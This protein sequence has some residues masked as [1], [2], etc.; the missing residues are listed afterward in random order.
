[1]SSVSVRRAIT[2]RDIAK[3]HRFPWSIY[4]DDP[5]WVPPL[6]HDVKRR[7]DPRVNPFFDHA[8]AE[9]YIA[10][11]DG[12]PVGRIAAILD[13]RHQEHHKDHTGFFGWFECENDA[14]TAL[15]LFATVAERLKAMGCDRM[16]GPVQSS[17]NEECG[18][19]VL[20]FDRSPVLM[21]P[22]NPPWY[23][24]LFAAAGLEKAM[25]LLSFDLP[26]KDFAAERISRVV[27]MVKRREKVTVR[28]FNMKEFP[29]EL[30]RLKA[31]YN[32]AWVAN[33][34][35]VPLTDAELEH[36][37]GDLKPIIRPELAAFVE[38]NG[39]PVG[40]SLVLPNLNDII[41]TL[42][43][44]LFPFGFLKILFGVKKIRGVRLVAMGVHRDWQHRGLDAAL[45]LDNFQACRRLGIDWSDVGWVLETNTVMINTIK[46]IGGVH[47]KTH[48][49]FE[50]PV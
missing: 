16:R 29:A 37:A 15:L 31:V 20:G 32:D 42:N 47:Y 25:D 8:V 35:F 11:R 22:H 10:E 26:V 38:C 21:M 39:R 50:K 49:I 24:D 5:L 45:Y 23:A 18:L 14:G 1:M 12:R 4:R 40:F 36:M 30:E 2:A 9:L 13:R 43:G 48:R 27:D 33:W 44:R 34:G 46:K 7:L 41:K 19:Q 28:N 17:L 3:F 6:L